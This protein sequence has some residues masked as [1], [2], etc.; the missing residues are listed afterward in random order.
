MG[1]LSIPC[2]GLSI[3]IYGCCPELHDRHASSLQLHVTCVQQDPDREKM[4]DSTSRAA[5][6][7]IER[8]IHKQADLLDRSVEFSRQ[9]S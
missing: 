9:R 6:G 8:T 5:F 3:S 4:L 2:W 7:H 1:A